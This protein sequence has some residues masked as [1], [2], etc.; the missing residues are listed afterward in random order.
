[1][2][3]ILLVHVKETRQEIAGPADLHRFWQKDI[4]IL[5]ALP[6]CEGIAVEL[7]VHAGTGGWRFF[8]VYPGGIQE[9]QGHVA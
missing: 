1:M 3:R 2:P 4:R 8:A 5:Q 7:W 9:V 6:R